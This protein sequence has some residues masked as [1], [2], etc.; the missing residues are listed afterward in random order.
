MYDV[1]GKS[2]IGAMSGHA[3]WVLSVDVSPGGAAIATGSSDKTTRLW[4]L[5]IRV[6]VQTMSNH[7]DQVWGVAFCLP[8]KTGVRAG[9]LASVLNDRSISLFNNLGASGVLS[10]LQL[11]FLLLKQF[12]SLSTFSL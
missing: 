6:V 5:N 3:S 10:S 12:A 1:K 4:D 9:R 2:L 7:A 11:F 8:G